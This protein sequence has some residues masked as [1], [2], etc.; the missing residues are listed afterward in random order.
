MEIYVHFS[1]FIRIAE[2]RKDLFG[3]CSKQIVSI[4]FALQ[5]EIPWIISPTFDT[6]A[7][8]QSR[9]RRISFF[10]ILETACCHAR[11]VSPLGMFHGFPFFL[12]PEFRDCAGLVYIRSVITRVLT[13]HIFMNFHSPLAGLLVTSSIFALVLAMRCVRRGDSI[14]LV[15][16]RDHQRRFFFYSDRLSK[17]KC[18]NLANGG[19][20][21]RIIFIRRKWHRIIRLGGSPACSS[22][23]RPNGKNSFKTEK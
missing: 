6:S 4:L 21:A 2:K 3:I 23:S 1:L 17:C 9:C 19:M 13:I 20:E 10:P 5:R 12:F 18:A 22:I 16:L 7:L 8:I 14:G 15:F 11:Q